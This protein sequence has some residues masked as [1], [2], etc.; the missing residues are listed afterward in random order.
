MDKRINA[1]AVEL[2]TAELLRHFP[3]FK[4]TTE[5]SKLLPG[6]VV[7]ARVLPGAGS[8]WLTFGG[9][10]DSALEFGLF[11][12]WSGT[13]RKFAEVEAIFDGG[14]CRDS[15]VVDLRDE[16]AVT[17]ELSAR[18]V[19]LATRPPSEGLRQDSLRRYLSS[20][21]FDAHLDKVERVERSS[22]KPSS[23]A[24]LLE[25]YA[26]RERALLELWAHVLDR[27]PAAIVEMRLSVQSLV[28][29]AIDLLHRYGIQYLLTKLGGDDSRLC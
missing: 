28:G 9:F 17:R 27:N 15:G 21:E 19:S 7:F 8:V 2:F 16:P 4:K 20:Q 3:E 13:S 1:V 10:R 29:A 14:E 18:F 24:A 12:A 23:R 5:R 11:G 26:T 22:K 25:L 6:G